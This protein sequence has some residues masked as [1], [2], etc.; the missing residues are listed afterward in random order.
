[1]NAVDTVTVTV[2]G[3]DMSAL[4]PREIDF[5]SLRSCSISNGDDAFTACDV[6]IVCLQFG[7]RWRTKK[8]KFSGRA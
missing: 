4:H 6:M 1:M 5:F 8:E 3:G 2:V 7:S